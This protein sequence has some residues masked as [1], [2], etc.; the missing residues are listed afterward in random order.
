MTILP[1]GR[2][3][4]IH[5]KPVELTQKEFD[6]FLTLARHQ[7]RAFTRESLVE[8]IWGHDFMGE[9]RVIDTHIKNVRE[10]VQ[11]AGLSYNPIQ[12]VWGVGYKFNVPGDLA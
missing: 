9:L 12:T 6:L 2:Q 5:N 7:N 8:S 11:Q 1:E 3:I 4:L 10:K